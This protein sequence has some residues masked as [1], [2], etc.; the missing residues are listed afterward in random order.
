MGIFSKSDEEKRADQQRVI[1]A[2]NHII[3]QT[4]TL[5]KAARNAPDG[6]RLI[7]YATVYA[8]G[9]RQDSTFWGWDAVNAEKALR[10]FMDLTGQ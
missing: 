7:A 3:Q 2:E 10:S 5:Q 6:D 9:G 8:L 4:E 1:D